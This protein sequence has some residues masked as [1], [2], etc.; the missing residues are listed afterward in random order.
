MNSQEQLQ[1][2]KGETNHSVN[3]KVSENASNS[4]ELTMENRGMELQSNEFLNEDRKQSE[5]YRACASEG[6][7]TKMKS[8]EMPSIPSG[9][10]LDRLR[11]LS[12]KQ[13]G[14][15]DIASVISNIVDRVCD[16][17]VA[18]DVSGLTDGD[19]FKTEEFSTPTNGISTLSPTSSLTTGQ[20]TSVSGSNKVMSFRSVVRAPEPPTV[21]RRN[22]KLADIQSETTAT[23][24][25]SSRDEKTAKKKKKNSVTFCEVQI[26][27]YERVLE[28]NPSV[29][30]GPA[31]G[32]GWNYIEQDNILTLDSFEKTRGYNPRRSIRDLALPRD[33]REDMLRGLGYSNKE[34]ACS[35]R[36]I[37]RSKNQRKQT[38]QNLHASNVEE[39]VEKATRKMKH[40]LLFPLHTR[41]KGKQLYAQQ[42]RSSSKRLKSSVLRSTS[43]MRAA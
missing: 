39:F 21:S 16:D 1:Q 14:T 22:S 9:T 15:E 42:N 27:N 4:Y 20:Q 32:I 17:S 7:G 41:K 6:S 38:I 18:S 33:E 28:V 26:R 11:R 24:V 25:S 29:T 36:T 43:P 2:W 37:L 34:I 8:S 40:V 35:V 13:E 3:E 10:S 19:I 12:A 31:V 5:L 23:T 30:S